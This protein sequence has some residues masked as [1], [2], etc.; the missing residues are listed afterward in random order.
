MKEKR[1]QRMWAE[2]G[3]TAEFTDEVFWRE[4]ERLKE[5]GKVALQRWRDRLKHC[6]KQREKQ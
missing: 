4:Y 6:E 3:E 5:L 1:L 2:D